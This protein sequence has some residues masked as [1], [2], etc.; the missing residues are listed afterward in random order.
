[1]KAELRAFSL[2]SATQIKATKNYLSRR[3]D[4]ITKIELVVFISVLSYDLFSRLISHLDR[5][6]GNEKLADV[7]QLY[8]GLSKG[9]LILLFLSGFA[10]TRRKLGNSRFSLLLVQPLPNATLAAAR[11]VNLL[12]PFLL[13]LPFWLI[14]PLIFLL[15]LSIAWHSLVLQLSFQ[16][17]IYL[18][19]T[20]IGVNSAL[21]VS[22]RKGGRGRGWRIMATAFLCGLAAAILISSWPH[23]ASLHISL[24]LFILS[25]LYLGLC[26]AA[27]HDL[28]VKR[29]LFTPDSLW[30][31]LPRKR[32]KR[33]FNFLLRTYVCLVPKKLAPLVWKDILFAA[34]SYKMFFIIFIAFLLAITG[35]ILIAG[36]TRDAAQWLLSLSIAAS[37]F[38]ANAAFKFNEEGIERLQVIK[39]HPVS[40]KQYWW[41]KFWVGFLP[42]LWLIIIGHFILLLRHFP[43]WLGLLQSLAL[44]LFVA[45]TLVFVENNFALYSYPYARY[46][47]LWYNLYIITAGAFFTV[48]LFPPLAIAFLL[49]GYY[50]IFRVQR[51]MDAIE[52]FS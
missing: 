43:G 49:F 47:P 46:A 51:R 8:A 38:L 4:R 44:S 24:A 7:W 50:A 48:L 13:L 33:S 39:S 34:R 21:V 16:A 10:F 5:L 12:S 31:A 37:Y 32:Y 26:Y 22:E 1:M 30:L 42:S 17:A 20:Q 29:I 25:A 15:K 35:I 6:I 41:S 52:V 19:F 40:A 9:V 18:A 11:L 36:D 27:A 28:L 45:V 23:D 3:L 2:I 14:V